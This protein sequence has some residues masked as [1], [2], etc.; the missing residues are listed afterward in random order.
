MDESTVR[1]L[2][3]RS[4]FLSLEDRHYVQNAFR[5][6]LIFGHLPDDVA[7]SR[8][9]TKTLANQYIIPSMHT[10]NENSKW[11]EGPAQVLGRLIPKWQTL[12]RGFWAN[13]AVE[14]SKHRN[15][16]FEQEGSATEAQ[17][18]FGV[19]Y[20]DLWLAA[21]RLF[22]YLSSVRPRRTRRL[23]AT[24]PARSIIDCERELVIFAASLGFDSAEIRDLVKKDWNLAIARDLV[25]QV[26]PDEVVESELEEKA[27]SVHKVLTTL[28][29]LP[30]RDPT[31]ACT[32]DHGS[33]RLDERCGRIFL[34]AFLNVRDEIRLSEVY[35]ERPLEPRR[36][37]TYFASFRDTY[38][39]FLGPKMDSKFRDVYTDEVW[40]VEDL[41][42]KTSRKGVFSKQI[43]SDGAD[44]TMEEVGPNVGGAASYTP[45]SDDASRMSVEH[46]PIDD[47]PVA[48][49]S[50]SENYLP[51]SNEYDLRADGSMEIAA[52]AMLPAI[53]P[54]ITS[55]DNTAVQ[56]SI[57]P[58]A[59][60]S[61]V[62][63][64]EVGEISPPFPASQSDS[65]QLVRVGATP[66]P[67]WGRTFNKIEC[68][69]HELTL[70]YPDACLRDVIR[71]FDEL[72]ASARP[73]LVVCAENSQTTYFFS[74]AQE[75][76][77]KRVQTRMQ[78]GYRICRLESEAV[79][80]LSTTETGV[81]AMNN[82]WVIMTKAG[83]ETGAR[84]TEVDIP[85]WDNGRW[86]IGGYEIA[87]DEDDDSDL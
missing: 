77:L 83:F 47:L 40:D 73:G 27:T 78:W 30:A 68:Q 76:F 28:T 25:C 58:S 35:A 50:P 80:F 54:A 38:R 87:L 71:C 37:L 66:P 15:H 48:T 45:D 74:Q 11:I 7:K 75:S 41:F 46:S 51:R 3:G 10:F 64:N 59:P 12:R 16:H 13:F 24:L 31:A 81:I 70:T 29:S 82:G 33:W 26:T 55:S 60:R 57:V 56:L 52:P 20:R 8:A 36:Q 43:G 39:A 4:P 44:A 2:E 42:K 67:G 19:A 61:L 5:R 79:Y 63:V 62:S 34:D 32:T 72:Q 85:T 9:M 1:H 86:F 17:R 6:G 21:F 65:T 22:P 23:H 49:F 18:V 69:E 84:G 14:K 53:L